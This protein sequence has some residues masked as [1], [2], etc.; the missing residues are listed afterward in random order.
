[1]TEDVDRTVTG[2]A[3]SAD[4]TTIVFDR[5][6]CGPVVVFVHGAFTGRSHPTLA[7]VARSLSPWFTVV[8]YDR[9]GRGDSGDTRPYA[10]QREIEDLAAVIEAA[11]GSRGSAMVFGGSSGA[12]LALEAAARLPSISALALWEPPYHVDQSAPTLPR[13]FASRLTALVEAGARGD[14]VELFM[15][16][17]AEVPR[18]T[19]TTM[20]AHPSWSEME[21]L[22]HTLAY[23]AEVM[24]PGNALPAHTAASIRQPVVILN[25]QNSPA[26]MRNAGSALVRA[27]PAA[28]HRLLEGQAHDVSARALIPEL[29]EVFSKHW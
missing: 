24:G 3:T 8:N 10:P 23:E 13:D 16:Q 22:A 1:V 15:V 11:A 5:N 20:R 29:V 28:S 17:A 7:E 2:T 25:G 14:A 27:I 19:V 4:G 26:W 9:R 21:A 18:E 6:G 12:A